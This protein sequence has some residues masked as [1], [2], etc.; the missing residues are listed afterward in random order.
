MFNSSYRPNR[1]L[2]PYC[3]GVEYVETVEPDRD[4]WDLVV[5]GE[6]TSPEEKPRR[7]RRPNPAEIDK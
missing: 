2:G 4:S 5:I 7:G 1:N 6:D 3:S